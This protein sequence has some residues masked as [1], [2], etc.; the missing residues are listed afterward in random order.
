MKPFSFSGSTR[1]ITLIETILY[2]ALLGMVAVF[3]SNFLIQVVNT[4]HRARAER[5]VISN[6]R[7]ILETVG[8]EIASAIGVY[9]PT[10][11]FNN[12]AGQLSLMTSIGAQAEHQTAFVDFW[13]DNGALRMRRE[14]G[15]EISLSAAT[16]R[17]TKL[18]FGRIIQ[19]LGRE[20]IQLT[21]QVDYAIP[22]FGTSA[23]LNSTTALRG[24]Y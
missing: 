21:L 7:L 14:G 24:N 6:G 15:A 9:A 4:Y 2:V 19:G 1:G 13:V 17:V 12:D 23:T 22:K 5:E 18:R 20:A 10:S 3:I 11:R 8:G 16:V